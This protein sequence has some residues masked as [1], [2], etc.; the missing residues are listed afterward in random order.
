MSA[1]V[2]FCLFLRVRPVSSSS[3]ILIC[4]HV[5]TCAYACVFVSCV[6]LVHVPLPFFPYLITLI[7]FLGS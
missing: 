5:C 4:V 1:R 6:C 2:F 7:L 3:I